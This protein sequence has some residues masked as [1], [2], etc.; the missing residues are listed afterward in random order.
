[1]VFLLK[2]KQKEKMAKTI[3]FSD[4]QDL[5][6]MSSYNNSANA[7]KKVKPMQKIENTKSW[8]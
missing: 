3:C 4:K 6:D 2:L 7:I 1:M 8:K 5:V